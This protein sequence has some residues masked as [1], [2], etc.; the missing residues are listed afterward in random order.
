MV[1]LRIDQ[2]GT[3]RNDLS[4]LHAWLLEDSQTR[5]LDLA[6]QGAD[7]GSLGLVDTLLAG[8]ES[9][10]TLG[11]LY[12]AVLSYI[13]NR[14][15]SHPEEPR[16]EVVITAPDGTTLAVR[17][18]PKDAQERMIQ[19]FAEHLSDSDSGDEREDR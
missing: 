3:A 15:M 1:R 9:A 14:R 17:N 8:V 18:A 12:F 7:D 11:A 4:D 19:Q 10:A 5:E 13:D 2:D 6:A 16:P